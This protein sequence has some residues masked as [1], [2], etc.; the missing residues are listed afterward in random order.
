MSLNTS[1]E[2]IEPATVMPNLPLVSSASTKELIEKDVSC[3][4]KSVDLMVLT[5]HKELSPVVKKLEKNTDLNK[6]KYN[7]QRQDLNDSKSSQESDDFMVKFFDTPAKNLKQTLKV[8][9]IYPFIH[10]LIF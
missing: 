9:H 5:I 2:T 4:D 8:E 7:E 3:E 1:K 6:S 10:H